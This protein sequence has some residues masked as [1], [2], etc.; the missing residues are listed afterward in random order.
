MAEFLQ[1]ELDPL[2]IAVVLK[3]KHMCMEMRGIKKHDTW[4]TTSKML[5]VFKEN[6]MARS[7]F[8]NLIK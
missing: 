3:A 5:G 2:G 8:I 7:E 1:K 4:T 6:S